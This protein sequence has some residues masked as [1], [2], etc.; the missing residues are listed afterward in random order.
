M[1][2]QSLLD[3]LFPR[4]CA[5]CGGD[6]GNEFRYICWNC[7]TKIRLVQK[8]YCLLC[9]DPVYGA[10]ESEYF[11]PA[12]MR[13]RPF[14][15][16]ARS[17]ALY[18]DLAKEM[19]LSFKYQ[20]ATWL[21]ADLG[22]LLLACLR[23]HFRTGNIDGVTFVPLHKARERQ[24]TYN[25]AFLLAREIAGHL[26]QPVENCLVRPCPTE[27]QTHLT[28]SER[29]ANVSNKFAIKGRIAL[30]GK[31]LLLIDDVMTTGATVNECARILKEAGAQEVLVLTVA[32]G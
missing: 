9:G 28:A 31:R 19:I 27:S 23:L 12:C 21:S 5:G 30:N 14:F 29:T 15:D 22:R 25:Q 8:P 1:S 24:R 20:G 32:R 26:G 6:A 18:Q 10:I 2:L 13:Q 17:A 11:C 4:A 3:L 16:C 7:L